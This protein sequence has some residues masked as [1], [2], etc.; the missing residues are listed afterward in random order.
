MALI[1]CPECKREIS[2]KADSCPHCGYPIDKKIKLNVSNAHVS[3]G[4]TKKIGL[5]SNQEND[6]IRLLKEGKKIEAIKVYREFTGEGLKESKDA[7]EKLAI[8]NNIELP[9][10]TGCFIATA[11]YG[12]PFARDV[13]I[14]R[15]YR[16]EVLLKRKAGRIF[17]RFYYLISPPLSLL[18]KKCPVLKS[19]L[20]KYFFF[21]IIKKISPKMGYKD[22][23]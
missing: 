21:T 17:V 14:L 18:I 13:S 10:E 1:E 4:S 16:D 20:R 11:C 9:K 23:K 7:V 12:S 19:L 2:D 3:L 6:I 15:A 5:N 22:I 8:V